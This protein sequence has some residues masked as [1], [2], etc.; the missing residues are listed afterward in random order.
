MESTFCGQ[1][2]TGG[3]MRERERT[4]ER[5]RGRVREFSIYVHNL[6]DH[7]DR[8]G[9]QEIFQKAG[10]V[11]DAYIPT[12]KGKGITGRYGFVRFRRPEEA[13]RS[14]QIF[15]GTFIRGHKIHVARA[16]PK[17]DYK[18]S[19]FRLRSATKTSSRLRNAH[20]SSEHGKA[21]RKM[22]WK[23]KS[24]VHLNEGTMVRLSQEE[25]PLKVSLVGQTN[26]DNE[27]WLR[28][29]LVC[30]SPVPRDL[31]TLS[32]AIMY[33]YDPRIK[34]R[35]LSCLKYILTF[36]TVELMQEALSQEQELYQWFTEVKPWG[37]EEYCDSRKVWLVIHGVPPH[38]WCWE[39]FKQIAEL[40]GIFICLGKS[41][42]SNDS[43][44]A[45]RVLIATKILQKI[46][47][48]I[49]LHLGSCGYRIRISEAEMA[50]QPSGMNHQ[51][52]LH[53]SGKEDIP[54]FEDVED[55]EGEELP[56]ATQEQEE[57]ESTNSQANS[58][59]NSG[60]VV[61][62]PNSYGSRQDTTSGTRTKTASFSQ[63][64]YSEEIRKV[65]LHLSALG[66]EVSNDEASQVSQPPP[67]FENQMTAHTKS[68]STPNNYK[69]AL[70]HGI[71]LTS[72]PTSSPD[73]L[74]KLA[75]N[76]LQIGELLGVKVIENLD[77][78]I[79]RITEPLKRNRAK[80]R[81]NTEERPTH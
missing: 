66:K 43:F 47:S 38:G 63:N 21:K 76:S 33:G 73:S 2:A 42:S 45:M 37:P 30:T 6:P 53:S 13:N 23:P 18:Q 49:L 78:A 48:E 79:S 51:N 7:L 31:D 10:R 59:S 32:S 70:L 77:T 8:Y 34:L 39:N 25:Q 54:G 15:H 12:R 55:S 52:S 46:D 80:A 75:H 81:S 58:N 56:V 28:R 44:E 3:E 26:E 74:V 50:S 5:V 19:P 71:P 1:E 69:E 20:K 14:I 36:P 4:K 11:H 67:G 27:L 57:E 65:N 22:V 9:L 61:E 29:S 62:S 72:S 16:N 41:T 68:V 40:W 24:E 35:A 17:S 64:G 60:K